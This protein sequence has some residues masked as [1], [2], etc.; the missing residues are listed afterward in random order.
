[1]FLLLVLSG[2]AAELVLLMFLLPVLSGTA[3]ELAIAWVC[4]RFESVQCLLPVLAGMAA[5]LGCRYYSIMI[6]VC[7]VFY[8]SLQLSLTAF[9]AVCL[10]WWCKSLWDLHLIAFWHDSE[11]S[12]GSVC[13]S[14]VMYCVH[15]AYL[16]G[17]PVW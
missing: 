6:Y 17:L 1:M 8:Y 4:V 7:V 2:T 3:A 5:A 13:N 10:A 9:D 11:S 16:D 15:V 12:R 14:Y